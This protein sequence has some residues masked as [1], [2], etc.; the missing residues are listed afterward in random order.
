MED[1]G[2]L[3]CDVHQY[4]EWKKM[5]R[6]AFFITNNYSML[7]EKITRYLWLARI[8]YYLNCQ[9][10]M[11]QKYYYTNRPVFMCGGGRTQLHGGRSIVEEPTILQVMTSPSGGFPFIRKV[12][13][14]WIPPYIMH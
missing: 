1:P 11:I 12:E 7:P 2:H 8:N 9:A 6:Q 4:S 13:E 3:A 14:H 5:K 10:F